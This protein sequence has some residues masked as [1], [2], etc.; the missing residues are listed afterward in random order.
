MIE[1]GPN[2]MKAIND[3]SLAAVLI[4]LTFCWVRY[5][6]KVNRNKTGVDLLDKIKDP[7]M[8]TYDGP[9]LEKPTNSLDKK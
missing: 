6:I 5:L 8:Y 4:T 3:I 7:P 1:I 2:L 9:P